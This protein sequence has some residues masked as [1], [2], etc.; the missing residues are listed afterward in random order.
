MADTQDMETRDAVVNGTK[1]PLRTAYML[2]TEE[3]LGMIG[4][5]SSIHGV[6]LG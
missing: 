4:A 1:L 5:L 6:A 3:T 2:G